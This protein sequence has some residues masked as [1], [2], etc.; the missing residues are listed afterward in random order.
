[1][2]ETGA[3]E[4]RLRTLFQ[5]F[6][7]SQTRQSIGRGIFLFDVLSRVRFVGCKE[8]GQFFTVSKSLQIFEIV[9]KEV[10]LGVGNLHDTETLQCVCGRFADAV[11]NLR[12][13]DRKSVV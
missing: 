4:A 7:F 3:L 11:P 6:R 10:G 12:N 2:F 5:M 1:M 13:Q 8:V 9:K